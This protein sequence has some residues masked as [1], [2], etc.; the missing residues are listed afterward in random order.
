VNLI[1]CNDVEGQRQQSI[2]RENCG[3]VVG[4]LVQRGTAAPEIAV[5]HR[6]QVVMDQRIAVDA[7]QRGAGQQRCVA[8]NAEHGGAFHHQKR[9]QPFAAA[10]RRI[11]HRVHQPVRAGD[12]VRQQDVGQQLSEQRFGFLCGAVQSFGKVDGC[13]TGR[14]QERLRIKS[15]GPS[16]MAPASSIPALPRRLIPQGCRDA[17]KSPRYQGALGR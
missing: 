7:F 6:R 2:A 12:F 14:H 1:A 13:S 17:I 4:F 16:V 9:P 8:R 10:E 15:A 11:T 5:V 3:G